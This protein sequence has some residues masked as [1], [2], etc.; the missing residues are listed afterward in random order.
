MD[1]HAHTTWK[2]SIEADKRRAEHDAAVDAA[3]QAYKDACAG[4][5]FGWGF[6]AFFAAAG[7]VGVAA[8]LWASC[9]F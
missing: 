3:L 7:V 5:R 1:H 4:E 6:A 2:N 9:P 8:L